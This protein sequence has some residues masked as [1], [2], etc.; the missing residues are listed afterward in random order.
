MPP[1]TDALMRSAALKLRDEE[2]L[3][4]SGIKFADQFTWSAILSERHSSESFAGQFL[5]P[6]F[7]SGQRREICR[8]E[9][10]TGVAIRVHDYLKVH[11]S[12]FAVYRANK[13]SKYSELHNPLN[14]E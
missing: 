13:L 5:K 3:L 7:R 6:C 2:R 8:I 10:V 12:L 14:H 9:L 4:C 11:V 1:I